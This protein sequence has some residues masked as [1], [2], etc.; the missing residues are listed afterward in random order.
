V[1]SAVGVANVEAAGRS[2]TTLVARFV[3][4][5]A[6]L[7]AALWGAVFGTIVVTSVSGFVTAYP[8]AA[9]RARLRVSLGSNAGVQALLGPTHRID[10]VAGFTAWRAVGV[11]M[12]VGAIWGLLAGTRFLRGEEEAGRWELLLTGSTTRGRAAGQA[13]GGLGAALVLMYAV[14]ALIVVAEGRSADAGFSVT[15]SMYLAIALVASSALFLAVGAFTS[16]LASTRRRAAGLAAGAFGVLFVIR[17]VASA[18]TGLRWMRW[19][20]PLG[21]IDELQPLTSPHPL[22]LLPLGAVIA[23]LVVATVR[24]AAAR[25]IGSGALRDHDTA[26]ARTGL[27]GSPTGLAVR[28]VRAV[29]LGWIAAIAALALIMGLVAQAAGKSLAGSKSIQ[30]ILERLGGHRTGAEAYL[31]FAFVII[32][33]VIA[34]L[35]ASQ[36]HGAREEEADG[37]LENLVVRPVTRT[38]WLAGRVGVAVVLIVASGV[39]AGVAAWVGAA[40]QDSGVGFGSMVEAGLNIVPAGVFVLGVGVLAFGVWPRAVN[41]AVYGIVAWSFLVELV[42]AS[43]NASHWLLDTSMLHHIKPAPA[44]DPDWVSAAVV[45]GIGIVCAVAGAIAFTRRDLAGA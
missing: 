26:V 24:L 19:L 13:V 2:P 33:I 40:T 7:Q 25:D 34:L 18:S 37:R 8:T 35:A 32:A 1:T 28:L 45:A 4:R 36:A 22:A 16:Q 11:A 17:M 44:A 30:Q 39:I 20:T 12:L 15:A 14:T 9:D 21:W 41:I 5:R 43:I 23:V 6:A 10:T 3:A 42:G 29:A 38:G 31:G 27:L